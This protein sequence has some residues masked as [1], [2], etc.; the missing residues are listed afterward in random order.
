MDAEN[1]KGD[2]MKKDIGD[3]KVISLY[4]YVEIKD[5]ETLCEEIR[6]FCALHDIFG[7]ILIGF[8]GINAAFSAKV[9]NCDLFKD[10]LEAKFPGLTYR[11]Q[12][13]DSH[14]FHKLV[15]RIRSEICVFGKDVD[16]SLKGEY[17]EPAKL[18]KWYSEGK[19]D[20]VIVDARNDYEFDV[21]RFKGARKLPI[22]TFKDFAFVAPKELADCK[23]KKV[24]LYCTGGI[25][26]EKASAFLKSEGFDSVY[27]VKGGI[28]NYVSQFPESNWEGGLFVFDDRKVSDVG[29]AVSSCLHCDELSNRMINCHNLD[30]DKLFLCCAKCAGSF[31]SSCSEACK[32]STHRR[33]AIKLVNK[34]VAELK[35]VVL[36][37]YPKAGVAYV[38]VEKDSLKVGDKLS[39][40]GNTTDISFE[41]TEMKN[42]SGEAVDS[43]GAGV[44]VT[45]PISETV[46]MND[47]LFA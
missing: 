13:L 6:A 3:Y 12:E 27:H 40:K 18:E 33:K 35:G 5:P 10:F 22:E 30:C 47:K 25:R 9:V 34:N 19:E 36:H 11:E 1:H 16:L 7:R 42:E 44:C 15:V 8:E 14:S 21:G 28:I 32:V 20:F 17:L 38:K 4:R 39:V 23:D 31:D 46:R 24:V 45:I 2:Q 26:C 41:V 43:V 37:Y 29:E